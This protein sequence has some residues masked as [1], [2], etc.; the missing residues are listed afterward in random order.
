[1]SS[2]QKSDQ[3]GDQYTFVADALGNIP[4]VTLAKY[5]GPQH[6]RPPN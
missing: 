5:D 1:L 3:K 2:E 4:L 6:G